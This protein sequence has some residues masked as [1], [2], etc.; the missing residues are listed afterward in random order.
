MLKQSGNPNSSGPK[1]KPRQGGIPIHRESVFSLLSPVFSLLSP[2]FCLLSSVFCPDPPILPS[3][4]GIHDSIMQNKPNLQNPKTNATSFTAK[5]YRRKPPLPDSKKQTQTN[6]IP[7]L[8][9]KT[10]A[11][12]VRRN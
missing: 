1:S 5:D 4:P 12:R 8:R 6:P 10:F 3:L 11:P 7:A 2:V 9:Q